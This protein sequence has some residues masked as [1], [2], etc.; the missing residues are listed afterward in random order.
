MLEVNFQPFPELVTERLILRQLMN[1]DAHEV[2]V[3]RSNRVSMQYI[4]KPVMQE[5]AEALVWIQRITDGLNNN[6]GI[7]WCIALKDCP[8]KLIG[9]IGFWRLIKEHYRAEI[10]YMLMPEYF[11]KG[12]ITEAVRCVN[13][14]AFAQ[15]QLHSI[16]AHI[17]PNN[18]GSESVLLK[19]GF[20]PEGYFK[21]SYYVNGKFEDTAIY[22]LIRK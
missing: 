4:A 10:G 12:Y 7:T 6:E 19:T 22:S 11:N 9:T 16:E 15:T 21:E 1:E 8:E 2:F 17:D 20:I 14:Y 13:E 18:K 5:E 3:M